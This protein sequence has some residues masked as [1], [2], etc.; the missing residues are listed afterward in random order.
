MAVARRELSAACA[1]GNR[2][3]VRRAEASVRSAEEAYRIALEPTQRGSPAA[4]L[5]GEM[6]VPPLAAVRRGLRTDQAFVHYVFAGGSLHALVLTPKGA[7]RRE[8]GPAARVRHAVEELRR[9][10]GAGDEP[11]ATKELRRIL[12]D[13]LG[14][15]EGVRRLAVSPD[16]CLAGV[17]FSLVS[18]GRTTSFVPSATAWTLLRRADATAGTGTLAMG[19]PL[20]SGPEAAPAEGAYRGVASLVPLPHSRQEV[21]AAT[22]PGDV[23]LLGREATEQRLRE[24][25]PGHERWRTVHFACHGI[26]DPRRPSWSALA[27]TPAEATDGFLTVLEILGMEVPADLVVLSAC[28][29]GV[30]K[31]IPGECLVALPTAFLHAGSS[32]VVA[33]LWRVDDRATK[34]FMKVFYGNLGSGGGGARMRVGE[35][36][37]RA[38]I[39]V[40]KAGYEDP[41]HWAGWVLWGLQ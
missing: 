16:G 27:L 38:R 12:V 22:G 29:T 11:A 34:L 40:R 33:S 19:D 23:R 2:D 25:L 9:E 8:L 4:V 17:P 32:R 21:I 35:A 37:E 39:A 20:Y 14:L 13:R 10:I 36:M 1:S 6:P 5:S 30:G 15:P 3:R 41:R 26:C 31:S 24:T 7:S 28:R 18:P